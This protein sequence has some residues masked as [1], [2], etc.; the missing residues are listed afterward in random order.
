M[1]ERGMSLLEVVV[2]LCLFAVLSLGLFSLFLSGRMASAAGSGKQEALC[3]A[4]A[5]MEAAKASPV[6]WEGQVRGAGSDYV[7]LENKADNQDGAYQDFYLAI[8]EGMGQGQVRK[9]QSYVGSSRTAYVAPSWSSTPDTS[10][11]YLVFRLG[12]ELGDVERVAVTTTPSS[13]AGLEE[14]KVVVK[15]RTPWGEREVQLTCERWKGT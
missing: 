2:A 7:V 8:I 1:D 12:S 9:I 3:L 11:R 6:E 14:V 13:T 4:R 5:V 15:Y 10:S